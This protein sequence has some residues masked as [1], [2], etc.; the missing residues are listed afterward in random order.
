MKTKAAIFHRA[1][2]PFEVAEIEID[3]PG[4]GDVLVRMAAVGICGTDLHV[5]KG[6][7]PWP[8]PIVLGHE[9]T[10]TV[11]AVGEDVTTVS[12]GDRVVLSWAPSCGQCFDCRRG[13]PAACDSLQRAVG[14][15]TRL[16]GRSGMSLNGET[17]YRAV[18]TGALAEH[19]VVSEQV[20]LPLGEGIPFEE[21]A[22]LGCA[23]LTGVGAALFAARIERGSSVL[24][25]GAGGV[26]QFVV[27]GA[28]I[29]EAA[30]IVCVDPV[31]RRR[32]MMQRLGATRAIA[33]E[34]LEETMG[35]L[36]PSGFD[37]ALDTVGDPSTVKTALHCTRHG[38]LCVIVG[39]G[40]LGQ[41]LELDPRNFCFGEKRLTGSLYGS[42]DPAR[43]LPIML[44]HVRAGRLDLRSQ[45]GP[46]YPL[47]Q[48]DNAV[49]ASLGGSPG[50]VVVTL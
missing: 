17:L 23:V 14:S 11:E 13:R 16:D 3:E 50:R 24:V 22:L 34:D 5:I 9:G 28:R 37:T 46:I 33:P 27:Q 35:E 41:Q 4:P 43:S 42:E 40:A 39:L 10:G 29:A 26:G 6:A 32:E 20:A 21:A 18:A 2:A 25:L 47:E 12:P 49:E 19:V 48:I 15:G 45:L 8:T 7:W 1:G 31:E 36:V 30:Q 44:E 38:G